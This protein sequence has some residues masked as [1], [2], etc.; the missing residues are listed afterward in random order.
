MKKSVTGKQRPNL[1]A[2]RNLKIAHEKR[3]FPH[4]WV[5]HQT[6]LFK[7]GLQTHLPIQQD[8]DA[9]GNDA[10]HPLPSKASEKIL[11]LKLLFSFPLRARFLK[12]LFN[13]GSL[14]LYTSHSVLFL[15]SCILIFLPLPTTVSPDPNKSFGS[16]RRNCPFLRWFCQSRHQAKRSDSSLV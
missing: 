8:K 12:G 14:H 9:L 2:F 1:C 5:K 13:A 15:N 7:K 3:P 10:K 11:V 6:A 16:L 4:H